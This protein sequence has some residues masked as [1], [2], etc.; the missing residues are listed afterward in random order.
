MKPLPKKQ[1][2][3]KPGVEP[4]KLPPEEPEPAVGEEPVGSAPKKRKKKKKKLEDEVFERK[5]L[6]YILAGIGIIVVLGAT[7]LAYRLQ[8]SAS[9]SKKFDQAVVLGDLQKLGARIDRD[10]SRAGQP[11]VGVTFSGVAFKGSDLEGLIAFPD[12]ERLDLSGTP[13]SDVAL[14]HLSELKTL[15]RLN[16]GHTNVTGGGMQFL[17]HMTEMEDLDLTQT[18]VDDH[19]LGQ[20]EGLKKLK[21]IHL[22]GSLASGLGLKAKIPDLEIQ[23]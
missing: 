6:H 4:E 19:R 11:I 18:L 20:L 8:S 23:R 21:K 14:E 9:A 22:D 5:S 3:Q 17:A 1:E 15:K 12:L 16:L 10:A 13:T 7:F 2:E